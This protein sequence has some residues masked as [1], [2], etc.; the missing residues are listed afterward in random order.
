M[1]KEQVFLSMQ[2][3]NKVRISICI[4]TFNRADLLSQT[5]QSV[6]NQTIRPYEVIVVD[7]GST[8]ET[9]KVG[10][11]YRK[12]YDYK[13]IVN[14]KNLGMIP[15][16]NKALKLATGNYICLLHSDDLIA[17]DWHDTWIKT[18]AKHKADFY[19]S[20][21]AIINDKNKPLFTAHI[22]KQ[23]RYVRQP[24][25]MKLFL[26]RLSP[27]IAP[28]GASIYS[29]KA[30]KEIGLFDPIYKTEADVPHFLKLVSRYDFYYRDKIVFAWRTHEAQTFD[31]DKAVKSE[32]GELIRLNNYFNIIARHFKYDYKNNP[33]WK[34]FIQTHMFMALSAIN[35]H[36]IKGKVAKV[37][38]SH[39]IARKHFPTALENANDWLKFTNIQLIL[40]RRAL[41]LYFI[42]LKDKKNLS[43]LKDINIS[44][45]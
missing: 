31:K 26:E 40:I 11:Y 4:P 1:M 45:T 7:N 13:F 10:E 17:P 29:K 33:K 18:I 19:T 42:S 22:F 27:M 21:I 28:S 34:I 6:A 35:L 43:W 23:D 30:L 15:N 9:S 3:K 16:W 32:E 36:L 20:A 38:R 12:K 14:R 41:T 24:H 5:L 25:T 37:I 2:S 8:D 44:K 39:Q